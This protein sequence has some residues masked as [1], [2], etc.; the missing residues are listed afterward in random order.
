MT[1]TPTA[2]VETASRA[3]GGTDPGGVDDG[4]EDPGPRWPLEPELSCPALLGEPEESMSDMQQDA[5]D[6]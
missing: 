3:A 4:R 5:L 2:S 6:Q 1:T